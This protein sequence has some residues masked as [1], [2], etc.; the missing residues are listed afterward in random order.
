MRPELF[1]ALSDP[2]RLSIVSLLACQCEPIQVGAVAGCCGIDLSGVSRHLKVLQ[3]A[4]IVSAEKRGR[5][6]FYGLQV[7]ELAGSLRETANAL[8]G[9]L[10]AAE[11]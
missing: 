8:E 2:V 4:G 5:D 10:Q 6:V 7:Q 9:R 11:K 3:R 1:K